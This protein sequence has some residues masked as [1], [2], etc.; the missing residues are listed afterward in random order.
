VNNILLLNVWF[1][2]KTVVH[3]FTETQLTN[4]KYLPNNSRD[5]FQGRRGVFKKQK[6]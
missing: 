1:V 3:T 6:Q 4:C 5:H 2:K